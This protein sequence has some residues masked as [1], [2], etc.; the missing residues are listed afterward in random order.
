[1]DEVA[2]DLARGGAPAEDAVD[3]EAAAEPSS[4]RGPADDEQR[5]LPAGYASRNAADICLGVV[6]VGVLLGDDLADQHGIGART[7]RAVAT[8][9]GTSTWAPRLTP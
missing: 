9:S 3:A 6:D 1:V 8:S 4:K 2:G 7:S 5:H